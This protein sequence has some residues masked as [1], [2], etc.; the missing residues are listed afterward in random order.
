MPSDKAL[1]RE[2]QGEI[3]KATR[4]RVAVSVRDGIAWLRGHSSSHD[5]A[6]E[7]GHLAGSIDKVREV[8]NDIVFPGK[9]RFKPPRK[10]SDELTGRKFDVVV[11]GGGVIGLAVARELSQFNL[12][13]ALFERHNDLGVDQTTHSNAM[14][15]P[16]IQAKH[17]TLR[18]EMNYKGNPM[19]DETARQLDV[20]FKRVGT[21]I[22]A[23]NAAEEALLPY[24][25]NVAIKHNDPEPKLLDRAGLDSLEPGLAPNVRK[26]VLIWNT[27]IINVFELLIAC[28]ENALSN[29]LSIFLDTGVIGV[30]TEDSA[31]KAIDTSRGTVKAGLLINAA[32]LYADR[33]AEYAGDRFFT[34]HP[35]K[36]ETVIFD[37]SYQPVRTI[38]APVSIAAETEETKY[39]KGGGIIPTTDGNLQFGP[40]A[41]EVCNRED[42]STTAEGCDSLFDKFAPVLE[43]LKPEYEK[44]D[45]GKIIAQ[46]AGCRAAT[47]KEDFIIEPSKKVRGLV[48]VAGIQSPGLASAPAIAER[49]REI[50]REERHPPVNSKF[51]PVRKRQ[52]RFS[53]LGLKEQG[54]L[55]RTNPLYGHIVCRCENVSEAE[56]V[57]ALHG[58]IPARSLDGV[59]RRTRAGQG[60]CQGGFCTPRIMEIASREM[61]IGK[62]HLLKS[63]GKSYV[64]R[65]RTK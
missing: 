5:A 2:I 44:P 14:I 52:A 26:G 24:A 40:T 57:R 19:W 25:V 47:Y 8:V 42:V 27:G 12:S 58:D 43:R 28:A 16:A 29:G 1:A 49:V 56:V 13:V 31:I 45:K 6:L 7:A 50:I 37:K 10:V 35:R 11:V 23:E 61:H 41:I 39:T 33:I 20:D 38:F 22:V 15:H 30:Q 34:I 17:G 53:E 65:G 60:R 3:E 54:E 59:K 63:E 32:G 62:E 9:M 64:L 4:N 48:H 55:I 46:F 36:G 21:L 51:N 18:W